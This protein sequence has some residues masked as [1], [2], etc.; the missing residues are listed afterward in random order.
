MRHEKASALS[1][2]AIDRPGRP[3]RF[4]NW[5][6]LAAEA[7]VAICG[8]AMLNATTARGPKFAGALGALIGTVCLVLLIREM[9]GLV[10]SAELICLPTNHLTPIPILSFGRRKIRL[11]E[12]RRMTVAPSWCGFQLIRIS[13]DFGSD[14]LVFQSSGQRRRF[15]SVIQRMRPD[16]ELFRSRSIP[17]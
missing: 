8:F 17:G 13:G 12:L 1:P 15:T 4:W 3:S 14:V 6:L 10:V 5:K 2:I 9:R 16:V 11:A 7:T